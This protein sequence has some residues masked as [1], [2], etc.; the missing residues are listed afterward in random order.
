MAGEAFKPKDNQFLPSTLK[1]WATKT[2]R[3]RKSGQGLDPGLSKGSF[4]YL[5]GVEEGYVYRIIYEDDRKELRVSLKD[6]DTNYPG[7]SFRIEG[8]SSRFR[9][10][11]QF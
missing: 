1:N 4:A 8:Q 3:E 2:T 5:T 7:T 11:A 6:R 9:A 10:T